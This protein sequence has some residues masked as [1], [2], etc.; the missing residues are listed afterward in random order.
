MILY[1]GSYTKIESPDLQHSREDIDF[2]AGFYLTPDIDMEKS[3]VCAKKNSVVSVYEVDTKCISI[4]QFG[5]DYEWLDYIK[6]N[7]R[8]SGNQFYE[9][10]N[11]AGFSNQYVLKN[12]KSIRLSCKYLDSL[13]II[14]EEKWRIRQQTSSE[15]ADALK[16]LKEAKR[17][18][19]QIEEAENRGRK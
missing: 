11:I 9:Y 12:E 2:G 18:Y 5:L 1:H 19:A 3:W 17:Y 6:A 8:D 14:G 7:Q 15:R 4:H 13:E 10:L 16:K